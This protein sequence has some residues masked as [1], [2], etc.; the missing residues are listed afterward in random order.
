MIPQ[1]I[2]SLFSGIG[3]LELGLEH[4]LEA[5]TVWQ[6]ESE[7]FCRRV[8]RQH[9]P[10]ITRFWD[11]RYV[12]Q[13]SAQA[14]D[15]ICGGFPCQ[16]ISSA[17]KRAGLAGH[18]SGLWFEFA[19]VIDELGPEW[20]VIEN[21]ASGASAW[22][23]AVRNGL[24][25]LGYES[26]PIPLAA[27]DLGAPHER[28]RIFIVAHANG[29]RLR[30]CEQRRSGRRAKRVRNKRPAI[31]VDAVESR[32]AVADIDRQGESRSGGSECEGR[33]WALRGPGEAWRDGSLEPELLR[34]AH[35]LPDRVDR[36]SA[37]G[38]S[39][40]PAAAIVIGRVIRELDKLL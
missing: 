11:V 10:D 27:V 1:T 25:G 14:V 39:V 5:K 22:V 36:I 19:R 23:D 40:V 31:A 28:A 16:D 33:R 12:N 20:A 38:N 6:A 18:R 35:G 9:W 30:Q 21:V 2:G 34:V 24:E 13:A 3:G 8:L 32:Q 37:L 4:A 29:E 26:L 7:V 15:L 17:G